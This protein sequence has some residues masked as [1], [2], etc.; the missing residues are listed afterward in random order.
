MKKSIL[1]LLLAMVWLAGVTMAV[2]ATGSDISTACWYDQIPNDPEP[3][4]SGFPV[5]YRNECFAT[6]TGEF[7]DVLYLGREARENDPFTLKVSIS[8]IGEEFALDFE[9]IQVEYEVIGATVT[10]ESYL[11]TDD[12]LY[13]DGI[14]TD[15]ILGKGYN[16][17]VAHLTYNGCDAGT[18]APFYIY[19][20]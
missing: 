15:F 9:K 6:T 13:K 19:V 7:N 17:I 12:P 1:V 2:F 3:S 4:S 16:E 10:S 14:A 5:V 11:Y 20:D 18:C 8:D